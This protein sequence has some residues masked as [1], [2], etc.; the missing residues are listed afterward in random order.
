VTV[1]NVLRV[2]IDGDAYRCA[3]ATII[4]DI[5]ATGKTLI[6][7]AEDIKVSLGTISNAKNKKA[8]L[9]AAYLARLGQVYGGSFLNPYFALFQSQ[10]APMQR[11]RTKDILPV[12]TRVAHKIACA[13]DPDGPGGVVEVPQEKRGYLRDLKE[14]QHE[15]GCLISEIEVAYA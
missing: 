3:V 15:T 6:D 8:D 1:P 14:L 12:V 2:P 7:I 11:R 10:A 4:E 5:E 9:C 13:R